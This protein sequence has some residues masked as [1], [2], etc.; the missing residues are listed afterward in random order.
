M[1]I[2]IVALWMLFSV[3]AAVA[4]PTPPTKVVDGKT[5]IVHKVVSGET[6]YKIAKKYGC[7]VADLQAA[8]KNI[9]VLKIGDEVLVPKAPS[10][11]TPPANGTEQKQAT[12]YADYTVKKGETLSK[13]ARDH[14]TTVEELKKI[15]QLGS[16]GLKIGQVIKVP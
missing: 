16:A 11:T 12:E 4:Q 1:R 3:S 2:F 5:Y 10:V 8:N 15:N 9:K 14:N 6:F 7:N 13:I